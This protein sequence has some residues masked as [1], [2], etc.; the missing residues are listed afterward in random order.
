MCHTNLKAPFLF[1][2]YNPGRKRKGIFY[3]IQDIVKQEVM[4]YIMTTVAVFGVWAKTVTVVSLRR[5]VRAAREIQKSQHKLMKLVKA[6][7]EHASLLT[8]RVQNV[9]AFVDKYLYEYKVLGIRLTRWKFFYKASLGIILVTGSFSMFE[10]VRIEGVGELLL[11]YAQWTG[12]FALLL[13]LLYF[14]SDEKGN[15]Q[16]SRNYMVEY[17]ENVCISRYAKKHAEEKQKENIVEE[18]EEEKEEEEEETPSVSEQEMRIR[19]ILEE[20]LA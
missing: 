9:N 11:H 17:L 8:D 3:M 13:V 18:K 4:I 19:A 5:M 12:L 1:L 20:F 6:K 2:R 14:V 10:S 15:L 7:F 16:V